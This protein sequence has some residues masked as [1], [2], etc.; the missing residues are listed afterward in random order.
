MMLLREDKR[1]A[2]YWE[3]YDL[4][5][6][7]QLVITRLPADPQGKKEK[8][9]VIEWPVGFSHLPNEGGLNNQSYLLAKVFNAFI[10]GERDGAFQRMSKK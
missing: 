10:A 5:R 8:I 9:V 6:T 1:L 7:K 3:S 2:E 4:C